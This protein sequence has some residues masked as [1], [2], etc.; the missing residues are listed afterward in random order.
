MLS[1]QGSRPAAHLDIVVAW[2]RLT[3]DFDLMTK[4]GTDPL[5]A[6]FGSTCCFAASGISV[7][8]QL[9]GILC[10]PCHM[11]YRTVEPEF[12][13][14]ASAPQYRSF[15]WA[16]LDTIKRKQKTPVKRFTHRTDHRSSLHDRRLIPDLN[17]LVNVAGWDGYS[18]HDLSHAS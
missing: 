13:L 10:H 14:H 1:I 7:I 3:R 9:I 5:V 17:D 11:A 6:F 4:G 15:A 18:L 12:Q 16:A 2:S 8:W